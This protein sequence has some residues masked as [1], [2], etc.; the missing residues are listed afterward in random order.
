MGRRRIGA[1]PLHDMM[2]RR[3][4]VGA[5][6][7]FLVGCSADK[8]AN[9]PANNPPAAAATANTTAKFEIGKDI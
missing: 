2:N 7:L 5:S 3:I 1:M 6:A 8:P 4:L 9:T